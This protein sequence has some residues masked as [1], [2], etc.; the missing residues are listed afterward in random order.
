MAYSKI[1]GIYRITHK[2]SGRHYVGSAASI[3]Q[4]WNMHRS[5]LRRCTHHSIKLQRAW[6]KHGADAFE[7]VIIEQ[8]AEA[9]LLTREQHWIDA[10]H[11]QAKGYNIAAVAG[12][13]VG[14]TWTE[15]RKRA[16]SLAKKG[17][18]FTDAHKAAI[19]AAL[20]GVKHTDDRKANQSKAR[21][22]FLADP[23]AF[24]AMCEAVSKANTGRKW[25]DETRAKIMAARAGQWTPERRAA[26]SERAR[27]RKHTPEAK[28]KIAANNSKRGVSEETKQKMRDA[29]TGRKLDPAHAA[30][31]RQQLAKLRGEAQQDGTG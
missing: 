28:A 3:K 14:C 23:E 30:K 31:S 18:V 10:L 5:R 27:G 25:S 16:A 19:S 22:E 20:T 17:A 8:C 7:F 15:E 24:A 21:K 26:A 11:A 1:T 12:R 4:R 2:V 9:E 29:L 6:D 13:T